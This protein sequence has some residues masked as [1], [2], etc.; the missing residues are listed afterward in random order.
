[1]KYRGEGVPIEGK[2]VEGAGRMGYSGIEQIELSR[3]RPRRSCELPE[4]PG[5]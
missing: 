4:T 5:G 1:M 3:K 2:S